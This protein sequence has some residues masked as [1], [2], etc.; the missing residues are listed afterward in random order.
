MK[1]LL[2]PLLALTVFLTSCGSR[3]SQP[4]VT[5]LD[6]GKYAGQ[7]H[8]IGRL[9][10]RFEHNIVAAKATYTK[11]K[12]GSLAILNEGLKNDGQRTK[13]NGSA[14]IPDPKQPGKLKV[15][16]NPFPANLF[17]GDYWIL[18]LSQDYTRALVGSPNRQ[19]L[20]VLSKREKSTQKNFSDFIQTAEKLGYSTKDIIWNPKRL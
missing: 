11:Q 7:W 12:D 3:V 2:L 9:P 14:T 1:I 10:N 15:S 6:T 16:F 18:G 17:A 5:Q 19:Y 8:E 20:W 4:T 13:I